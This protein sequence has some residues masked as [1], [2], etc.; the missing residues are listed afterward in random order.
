MSIFQT[1]S[2]VMPGSLRETGG[3]GGT[4]PSAHPRRP[5]RQGGK[6]VPPA[7]G[8]EGLGKSMA[9]PERTDEGSRVWSGKLMLKSTW[10]VT[11]V[12]FG[13]RRRGGHSLAVGSAR[14]A[15]ALCSSVRVCEWARGRG[16][17]P[18]PGCEGG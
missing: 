7:D 16:T 5:T 12:D 8:E 1:V 9:P 13:R 15:D 18:A 2:V 3:P 10:Q 14:A 11:G 17:R 6:A 4:S